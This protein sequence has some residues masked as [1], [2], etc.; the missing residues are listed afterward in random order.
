MRAVLE[1]VHLGRHLRLAQ[2]QVEADAVLGHDAGVGVG[3]KEE[4]WRGLGGDVQL[5]RHQLDQF[6]IRLLAEQVA[7]RAGMRDAGLEGDHRIA[8][9]QEVGPAAGAVDRVGCR[10]RC[11][12]ETR[13]GG[14]REVSAGREAHQAD[15]IGVDAEFLRAAAHQ[16]HGALRVAEL[17]RMA[18]L[19]AEPVLEDERASPPSR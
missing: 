15:P 14:R 18:I 7:H 19:R 10:R 3:M 2:R 9:D 12:V 11:R 16:P 13:A 17:D 6:R 8:E 4:R 1:D 5:V